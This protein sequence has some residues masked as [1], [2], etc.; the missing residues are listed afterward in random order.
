MRYTTPPSQRQLRVAEEI[1]QA[2]S[3]IFLRNEL[4]LPIFDKMMITASEVRISPDLKLATI[5]LILPDDSNHKEI[6]N[7]FNSLLPEFRKLITKKINLKF[8]PGIRFVSDESAKNAA[9][10]EKMFYDLKKE[11]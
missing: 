7:G 9:K 6:I 11:Q 2:V 3:E 10:I 8:S 1:R 5:F 4:F